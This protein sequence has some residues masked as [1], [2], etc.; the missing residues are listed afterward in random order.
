MIYSVSYLENFENK[1]QNYQVRRHVLNKKCAH[2]DSEEQGKSQFGQTLF[3]YSVRV[4][5]HLGNSPPNSFLFLH[6]MLKFTL[7]N[8]YFQ[9]KH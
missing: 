7:I 1:T 5:G 8:Q 9:S 6:M 3:K 4:L 2:R